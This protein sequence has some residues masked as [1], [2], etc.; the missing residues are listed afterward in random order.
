MNSGIG[1]GRTREDHREG[2]NQLYASYAKGK[3]MR[4]L[5]AIVGEDALSDLDKKYLSFADRF[6]WEMIHQGETP[7]S[8]EETLSIGWDLMK[9]LPKSELSRIRRSYIEKYLPRGG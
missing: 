1:E 7:R 9:I 4:R 2:A 6:E 8:I 3:D 5:V